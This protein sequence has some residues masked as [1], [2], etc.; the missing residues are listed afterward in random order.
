VDDATRTMST[1][2]PT[3]T[4]ES[5][6]DSN[7]NKITPEYLPWT[8]HQTREPDTC[9]RCRPR[10]AVSLT[11]DQVWRPDGPFIHC[12]STTQNC[13]PHTVH[14]RTPCPAAEHH[15]KKPRRRPWSCGRCRA[16]WSSSRKRSQSPVDMLEYRDT[17]AYGQ[18]QVCRKGHQGSSVDP[19]CQPSF[20]WIKFWHVRN[21]L[22]QK[23]STTSQCF[24]AL[25]K[26]IFRSRRPSVS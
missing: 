6:G 18:A 14:C 22:P 26:A 10:D 8:K 13:V 19:P 23:Y 2:Q 3:W 11:L 16:V 5:L 1:G 4:T 7:C 21:P 24:S 20:H 9:P 15:P 25:L 12:P 17:P